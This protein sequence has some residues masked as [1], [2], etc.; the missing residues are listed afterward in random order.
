[1]TTLCYYDIM[2]HNYLEHIPHRFSLVT[3]STDRAAPDMDLR[4]RTQM[5]GK[6]QTSRRLQEYYDKGKLLAVHSMNMHY[7]SWNKNMTTKPEWLHCIPIGLQSRFQR[8]HEII[9]YFL[10]Q[11]RTSSVERSRSDW[12]DSERPLLLAPF[13]PK[14]YA[15]VRRAA[16]KE[17]R[18]N[19]LM[20]KLQMNDTVYQNPHGMANISSPFFLTASFQDYFEAIAR[21]RFTVCPWGN[22]LDTNRMY[23]GT[24]CLH[25][26]MMQSC[27]IVMKI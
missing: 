14:I 3:H 15:R 7:S 10:G 22:G 6:K 5:Y 9:K 4:Q 2:T 25:F 20:G 23:E 27:V 8:T 12:D 24:S 21:H 16:L 19:V 1:M 18:N 17:L 13:T 26:I 11:M